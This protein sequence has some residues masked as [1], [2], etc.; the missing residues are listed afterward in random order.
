MSGVI[1]DMSN[2]QMSTVYAGE[3]IFRRGSR[4]ETRTRCELGSPPAPPRSP[5]TTPA[6]GH[7]LSFV[8]GLTAAAGGPDAP[9]ALRETVGSEVFKPP[10]WR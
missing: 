4:T 10:S 1:G 5:G 7:A 8:R 9:Q 2:S 3:N 6:T